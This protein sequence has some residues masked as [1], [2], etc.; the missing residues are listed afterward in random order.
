[1]HHEFQ[2][3]NRKRRGVERQH[4]MAAYKAE[5]E[6][7]LPAVAGRIDWNTAAYFFNSEFDAVQAAQQAAKTLRK[8]WS[9]AP[10]GLT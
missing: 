10:R 2:P 3:M 8:A 6:S 5:L 7:Q 4:W 9:E 1:M